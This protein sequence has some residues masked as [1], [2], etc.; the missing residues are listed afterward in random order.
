MDKLYESAL[1]HAAY[2][3]LIDLLASNPEWDVHFKGR[4]I[5]A[6][7]AG[8]NTVIN[9]FDSQGSYGICRLVEYLERSLHQ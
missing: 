3:K 7:H 1:L 2:H 8:N 5:K 6:T 9:I 4:E